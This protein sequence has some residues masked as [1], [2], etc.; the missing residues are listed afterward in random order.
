[1]LA[2]RVI[3]SPRKGASIQSIWIPKGN[4]LFQSTPWRLAFTA[5]GIIRCLIRGRSFITLSPSAGHIVLARILDLTV[6][7]LKASIPC[8]KL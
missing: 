5:N 4:L 6:I 8:Q 3:S 2:P 1:M 7:S